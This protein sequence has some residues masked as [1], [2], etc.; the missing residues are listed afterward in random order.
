MS[1]TVERYNR[2]V[3]KPD[4]KFAYILPPDEMK[5]DIEKSVKTTEYQEP[6]LQ[7]GFKNLR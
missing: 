4:D 5:K 1:D 3:R 2:I 7:M 6:Q